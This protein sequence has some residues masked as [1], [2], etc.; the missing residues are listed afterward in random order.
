MGMLFL[1]LQLLM[2]GI[3]SNDL[4]DFFVSFFGLSKTLGA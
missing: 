3:R 4:A 1:T 2:S